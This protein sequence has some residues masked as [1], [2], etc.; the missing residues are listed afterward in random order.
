MIV[1]C[2]LVMTYYCGFMQGV[3]VPSSPTLRNAQHEED[4]G[5]EERRH[6]LCRVPQSLHPLIAAITHSCSGPGVRKKTFNI[7]KLKL[8]NGLPAFNPTLF[9]K[10]IKQC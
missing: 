4:W 3:S 7:T 9:D 5:H 2:Y 8:G 6:L 10:K 1:S